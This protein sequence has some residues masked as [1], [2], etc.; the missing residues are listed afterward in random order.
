M[1][2]TPKKKIKSMRLCIEAIQIVEKMAREEN[3]NF[4]NMLETLILRAD[5]SDKKERK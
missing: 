1:T 3:R 5:E 4:T 2:D